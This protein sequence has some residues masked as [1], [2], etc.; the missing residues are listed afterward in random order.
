MNTYERR[1]YTGIQN[2]NLV[3]IG[4]NLYA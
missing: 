4:L 3:Q 2:A 1:S